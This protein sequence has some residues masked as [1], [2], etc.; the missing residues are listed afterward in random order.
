MYEDTCMYMYVFLNLY[1]QAIYV[2]T[3]AF[4]G[5]SSICPRHTLCS[6]V[7]RRGFEARLSYSVSRRGE[8]RRMVTSSTGSLSSRTLAA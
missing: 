1:T 4:L 7:S 6:S 2:G 8:A 3:A 5:Q